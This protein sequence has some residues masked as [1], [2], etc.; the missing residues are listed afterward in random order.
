MGLDTMRAVRFTLSSLWRPLIAG[1]VL[2]VAGITNANQVDLQSIHRSYRSMSA[3]QQQLTAK[4]L[5]A[6]IELINRFFNTFRTDNDLQVW[7]R[8]EF[9]ATPKELITAM[10][11]DCEDIAVAKYFAL[12]NSGVNEHALRLAHVK[13]Y[14]PAHA[15]IEEHLVLLYLHDTH[16]TQVLDNLTDEIKP[17]Q[18]RQDLIHLYSFN[19]YG[20]WNPHNRSITVPLDHSRV[21]T[22]WRTMLARFD[23]Q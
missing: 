7:G 22:N 10:A 12:V 14:N 1:G 5:A 18:Q 11:G 20:V 13:V 16:N 4:P 3:L 8:A 2:L 15:A 6:R 21:L 9:W 23:R 17:L 19:R